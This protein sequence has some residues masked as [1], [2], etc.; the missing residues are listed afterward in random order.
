MPT[1]DHATNDQIGEI[2]DKIQHVEDLVTPPKS[3]PEIEKS[4]SLIERRNEWYQDIQDAVLDVSN[5]LPEGT[6]DFDARMLFQFTLEL[7]KAIDEDPSAEDADGEVL[8]A[9][10]KIGDVAHRII[11][12]LVH[13]AIDDPNK[14]AQFVIGVLEGVPMSDVARIFGVSTKTVG[15]WKAGGMVARER[16]RVIAVAQIVSYLYGTLTPAGIVMWFDATR[17]AL[18]GRRPIDLLEEDVATAHGLLTSLARGSRGQ[19]AN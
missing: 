17:P 11:R 12:R 19:L 4:G 15:K 18:D 2:K 16:N 9:A 5:A 10:T 8:L 7:R 6:E 14:A 1:I 13:L 3:T